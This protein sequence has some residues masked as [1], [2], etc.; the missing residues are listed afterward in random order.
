MSVVKNPRTNARIE[1]REIVKALEGGADDYL[2]KPFGMSEFMARSRSLLRR[3]SPVET[4]SLPSTWQWGD[5]QID[6]VRRRVYYGDE[7][8]DLTPQEF[9]LLYVLIQANGEAL[10]RGELLQRA[11]DADVDNPRTVD[12]HILSLRKKLPDPK[13]IVTQ[14]GIGYALILNS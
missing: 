1:E 4:Q 5:L 8:I 2:K 13:S 14:R 6:L 12:S 3:V 11:W 7:L 9:S 10:S